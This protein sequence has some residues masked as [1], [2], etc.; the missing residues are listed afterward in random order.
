[1]REYFVAAAGSGEVVNSPWDSS[2]FNHG[3]LKNV[4][5]ALKSLAER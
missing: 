1:M 4:K 2:V 5:H 3:V